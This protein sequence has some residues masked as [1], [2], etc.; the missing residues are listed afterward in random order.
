MNNIIKIASW[1]FEVI[2]IF[3]PRKVLIVED[4]WNDAI[5]LARHVETCGWD[6]RICTSP[7][8]ALTELDEEN[9][10]VRIAF[11][12]ASF[13]SGM[14]GFQFARELL[15]HKKTRNISVTYVVGDSKALALLPPGKHWSFIPKDITDVASL[16]AVK[17][18]LKNGSI[19]TRELFTIGV[20]T[21]MVGVVVG[22]RLDKIVTIIKQLL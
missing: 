18:V 15:K 10:K 5:L 11:V 6:Y 9:L 12:D 1:L 13:P 16:E 8:Q 7:E 20:V 19:T 14:D 3:P 4:K 22:D 2:K 17:S 21:G